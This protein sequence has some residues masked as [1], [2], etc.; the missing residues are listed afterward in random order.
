M[1]GDNIHED[2][3]SKEEAEQKAIDLAKE[4]KELE[5]M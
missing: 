5:N 1:L 2:A 3:A 4:L